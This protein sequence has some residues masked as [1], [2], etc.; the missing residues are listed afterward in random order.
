LHKENIKAFFKIKIVK[1]DLHVL[2]LDKAYDNSIKDSNLDKKKDIKKSIVGLT[3]NEKMIIL[4]SLKKYYKDDKEDNS[5]T[6]YFRVLSLCSE[7]LLEEDFNKPITNNG[8]YKYFLYG[9]NNSEKDYEGKILII[10][11]IITKI[12]SLNGLNRI[13][14]ALNVH[15]T[16]INKQ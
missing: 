6:E 4:H 13:K 7:S 11:K 3:Q 8:K 14:R 12:E 5:F 10:D 2:V 1:D 15:K 16:Y 9:A